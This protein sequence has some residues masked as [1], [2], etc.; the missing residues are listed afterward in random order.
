MRIGDL[1][2]ATGVNRR[3]LRYYEEQGL[4]RPV[5]L[6]NGYREYSESDVT[7]VRHIRGLLAA[8]LPT[9]VIARLLHCVHDEGERLVPSGCPGMVTDLRRERSRVTGEIT[10][11]QE[12]RRAL[13]TL[14]ASASERSADGADDLG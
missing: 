13:D 2:G 10:R 12:S 7:A 1:A 5:R 8:G 4:L 3:L 9:A 14:L 11:L 6:A